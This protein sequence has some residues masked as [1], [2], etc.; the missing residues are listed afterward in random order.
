MGFIEGYIPRALILYHLSPLMALSI[1]RYITHFLEDRHR[2][3]RIIHIHIIYAHY[4]ACEDSPCEPPK[5]SAK[6]KSFL[7]CNKFLNL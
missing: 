3:Y 4:K 6:I 7:G 1:Y 2:P 5:L